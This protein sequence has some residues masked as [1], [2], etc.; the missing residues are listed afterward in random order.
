LYGRTLKG[1]EAEQLAKSSKAADFLAKP[2]EKRTPAERAELFD[3]WLVSL[4]APYR[5]INEQIAGI[6]QE[7]VVIK[8][9][10]NVGHVM[11][12]RKDEPSAYILFRGEYDQRRDKV[13]AATPHVL[14]P[15]PADL[16]R[17]RLGFAQWL[18]RPENPLPARVT[19]NRFWQEIFGNGLVRTSGDF[20]V[21]GELPSHPELLDWLAVDFRE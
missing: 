14:P 12:E 19:V 11:N 10:G 4:D 17:N 21:A 13:K 1:P 7:E 20:G 16:P 2:A 3:W 9:R 15:M 18:L 5:A 6:Q 8:S